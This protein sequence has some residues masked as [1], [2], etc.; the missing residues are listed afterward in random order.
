[1]A[2]IRA[3]WD[4]VGGYPIFVYTSFI[5]HNKFQ[6]KIVKGIKGNQNAPGF[7]PSAEAWKYYVQEGIASKE[8]V[9]KQ[10]LKIARRTLKEEG[11]I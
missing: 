6:V 7:G 11:L 10:A 8:G 3:D 2:R 9:V 1:M 4:W 5:D